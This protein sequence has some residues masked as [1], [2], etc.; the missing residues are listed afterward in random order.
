MSPAFF[1]QMNEPRYLG[2][3]SA[4]GCG[5]FWGKSLGFP[6]TPEIRA[7]TGT[8]TDDAVTERRNQHNDKYV[9]R[10]LW[11]LGLILHLLVFLY[12]GLRERL[13]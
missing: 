7:I 5:V 6:F 2:V 12:R 8:I 1:M 9:S 11:T 4:E 13:V 3:D 10:S